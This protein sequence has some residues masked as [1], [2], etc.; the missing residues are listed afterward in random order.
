MEEEIIK[1]LLS[2]CGG[3][4]P[5]HISR[6]LALLDLRGLERE[7]EKVTGLDYQKTPYAFFSN[8]LTEIISNLDVEKVK[9]EGGGVGKL[10]LRTNQDVELPG[11]L[12]EDI[13]SVL[14]AVCGLTDEELNRMVVN[15]P[16]YER[17]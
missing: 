13:E 11:G 14:D 12:K 15:H 8:R 4:H 16:L 9:P 10:I 7:G 2:R 1:Y 5:F 6:I 3:L 17:L